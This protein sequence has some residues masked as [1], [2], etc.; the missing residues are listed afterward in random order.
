MA[1]LLH[2]RARIRVRRASTVLLGELRLRRQGLVRCMH[3]WAGEVRKMDHSHGPTCSP[4]LAGAITAP[5]MRRPWI[6]GVATLG[7]AVG[8][9][10]GQRTL[11]EKVKRGKAWNEA[12]QRSD[13]PHCKDTATGGMASGGNH[14]LALK[15]AH[16]LVRV[17][18][19]AGAGHKGASGRQGDSGGRCGDRPC[20]ACPDP[21]R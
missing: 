4:G 10:W 3:G 21:N 9:G 13:A 8:A 7:H 16:C 18:N 11:R 2:P 5:P 15:S 1:R 19:S 20:T 6:T 14:P 17:S 12:R